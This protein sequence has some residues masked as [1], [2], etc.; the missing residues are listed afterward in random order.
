MKLRFSPTSPYVRKVVV[1]AAETGLSDRIE[2]VLTNTRDPNS[3]LPQDNPLGKVPVLITDDGIKLL[4]SPVICE[5]LDGLHDGP[6][7]V[8]PAGDARWRALRLEALADGILDAAV[9]RM[10]E[11][12]RPDGERSQAFADKQRGKI[13]ATL[14]VLEDEA[15]AFGDAPTI[16]AITAGCALGYLDFR[17]SDD[18]WRQ[19]R[20]ALAG[21]YEDFAKRPSMVASVP[22]EIA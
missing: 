4:D 14:D 17:F 9:L 19:G 13:V 18:D 8:P 21:W 2:L 15:P 5:Y 11:G 1:T 7:L 10:L 6:K 22:R 12:R 20:P 3:D 16:G